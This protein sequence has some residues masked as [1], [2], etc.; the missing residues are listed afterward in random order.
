MILNTYKAELREGHA[1]KFLVWTMVDGGSFSGAK[2]FVEVPGVG[3]AVLV[4][5]TRIR[6]A[7]TR[8][9]AK[10]GE[11]YPATVYYAEATTIEEGN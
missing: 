2:V 9:T 4:K 7:L 11:H 10:N 1:D 5:L 3:S 8:V 6:T